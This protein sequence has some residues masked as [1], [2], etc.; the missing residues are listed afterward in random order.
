[1]GEVVFY[2]GLKRRLYLLFHPLIVHLGWLRVL[3]PLQENGFSV[4][5][6]DETYFELWRG[7]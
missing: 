6:F 5:V 2:C 3:C 4:W 7:K 1:M